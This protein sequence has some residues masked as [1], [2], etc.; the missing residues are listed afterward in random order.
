MAGRF[1]YG[2]RQDA[3][4]HWSGSLLKEDEVLQVEVFGNDLEI[5]GYTTN[6]VKYI[7]IDIGTA[8]GIL[9][10]GV[11]MCEVFI[12]RRKSNK[13]AYEGSK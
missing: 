10:V 2:L 8:L 5:K 3:E 11:I 9:C 7:E 4:S 1:N 13:F 12:R 6:H